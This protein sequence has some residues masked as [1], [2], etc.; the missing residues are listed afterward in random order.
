MLWPA[1]ARAPRAVF[2]I[3][4]TLHKFL[5]AFSCNITKLHLPEITIKIFFQKPVDKPLS[6]WYNTGKLET[7]SGKFLPHLENRKRNFKNPLTNAFEYDTIQGKSRGQD[8]FKRGPD[9][10][11][12]KKNLKNHLTNSQEYGTIKVQYQR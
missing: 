1:R 4:C 3:L 2:A 6:F 9:G 11:N 5:Y 12:L 10:A 8:D 7:A